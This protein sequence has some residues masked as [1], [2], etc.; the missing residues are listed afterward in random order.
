MKLSRIVLAAASAAALFQA[1]AAQAAQACITEAEITGMM[2]FAL[3]S[4]LQ[5]VSNTCRPHLSADG[6]FATG[7][8]AM[9]Q[10]YAA[11]K[12][13][14]WPTAKA[15]FMKFGA[16]EDPSIAKTL[17]NLPDAALQPFVEAT[18]AEMIGSK[19]NPADCAN[20]ERLTALLEP[21]PPEN[22]AGLFGVIMALV[23]KNGAKGGKSPN[24]CPAT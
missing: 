24:I 5:G 2:A 11:G 23:G 9:I 19:V 18:M 16:A 15:A 3:P 6:F 8:N 13:A 7:G 17:G 21:L 1:Q 22:T 14:A 20:V 4:A 12:N 10:R